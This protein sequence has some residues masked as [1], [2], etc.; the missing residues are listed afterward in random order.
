V[1]VL[2]VQHQ[3][4][5]PPGLVGER[6]AVL[7]AEQ[8]VVDARE[9]HLLD[10]TEFDLVVPLGSDDSAADESVEYLRGEWELLER[11]VRAQ[12]PV[13]GI[14][15][16]AQLLCRVLGGAVAPA[17]GPEIGWLRVDTREP[18]LVEPGPWLVWHLD[19][20]EPGPGS[21][22]V[23]RTDVAVQAFRHGPH[24]GVQFHPEAT[25]A[26]V[27]VWAEH[28]RGSL[29]RLGVD[30]AGL[31]AETVERAASARSR[32]AALV[33]RVLARAGVAA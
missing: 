5:C 33:D 22:V 11:A 6:L 17:A 26:S 19:V 12:V 4:D 14:C 15:F 2:H 18:G 20:M 9:A 10:P 3:G 23:A 24:L 29:D 1:R 16:G 32:V 13:L 8:H 31:L 28:Y 27:R 25:I 30:P 21:V 7:G